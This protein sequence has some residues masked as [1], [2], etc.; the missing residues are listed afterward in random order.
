MSIFGL[1]RATFLAAALI[2]AGCDTS[3][4]SSTSGSGGIGGG[5]G[6]GGS[7]SSGRLV[8]CAAMSTDIISAPAHHTGD[9]N[10]LN[11][12]A[13]SNR[14]ARA[15]QSGAWSDAA[16]WGG[17]IPTSGA[18]V[19]PAGIGVILDT[20]L[21]QNL[22]SVRVDG[23]L[24]FARASN[25]RLRTDLLYVAPGGELWI[26]SPA[27]PI[28][29]NVTAEVIFPAT[30]KINAST[31]PRLLGKGLVSA[32]KATIA[33]ALKTSKV[34]TANAPLAGATTLS[35]A[36]APTGWNVGD[37]LVLTGTHLTRFRGVNGVNR[38]ENPEDEELTITAINGAS[39]TVSP[40]LR[41][42]H[43]TPR[44]SF[45]PYLVNFTRNVRLATENGSGKGPSE[46]GHSMFM[47]PQTIV[48]GAMFDEM[49][50]TDKSVRAFDATS[51][52]SITPDTNVKGRYPIHLHKAGFSSSAAPVLRNIA[53]WRSPGW[54]AAQHSTRAFFL[55]NA[56]YD[57]FG[58]GFV[59]ESGDERGAWVG[60]IAIK[61]EGVAELVK[62]G[63][64]VIAF[65]L[66][67]T[68]DGYWL[69]GRLLRLHRNVAAGMGAGMGFVYMHRG[70]DIAD[71][72]PITGDEVLRP[73]S[74]RFV[75]QSIDKPVIQQ[76]TQNE[77]F[78]SNIGFH[79]VKTGPKQPHDVRT[80]LDDFTAWEVKTG[81]EMT[82][83]SHYTVLNADICGTSAG[84]SAIG[85]DLGKNTYDLSV[86]NSRIENF[87]VGI[88]FAHVW[89]S[90][91]APAA[92]YVVAG[93]SL[94]NIR[95]AN[96]QNND[97]NDLILAST[98]ATKPAS[99]V[100][101]WGSSIP[102][103]NSA[104]G[105]RN[106][107]ITGTKTDTAGSVSYP[108]GNGDQDI[109]IPVITAALDANGYHTL[110]TGERI[111]TIPEFISDR[112]TGELQLQTFLI[113]I[114]PAFDVSS[115]RNNGALN[116]AGAAPNA[117][118]DTAIAQRNSITTINVL[119]N[120]SSPAGGLRIIGMTAPRNGYTEINSNGRI[121][122]SPYPGAPAS[123]AFS[124]W[125]MAADGKAAKADVSVTIQ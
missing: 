104:N 62:D 71:P 26:G 121:A 74:M 40:A 91:F 89:T 59:A 93:N 3:G 28:S 122:Y 123:D 115:Y 109:D 72:E 53:V 33:G 55:D 60:N 110:N 73:A 88:N 58:S 106:F 2:L 22:T 48:Q 79:V 16:T 10:A 36:S 67:R 78:A 116:P 12:I 87:D 8:T 41:F 92:F 56:V 42:N 43:D 69:Q 51:V 99:V 32:S 29:A 21:S 30:G 49:G 37:R 9:I 65:D 34:K 19:I 119:A 50:R 44:A 25:T 97:A 94:Q 86:A 77:V 120:D 76:F 63:A 52:A 66:G 95:V 100:F 46:R 7:G 81:I 14:G 102:F 85:I 17:S 11:S 45:Q 5:S 68:G 38:A 4:G 18:V 27:N 108:V 23:C 107:P 24:E 64:S 112:I 101:N 31:D 111:I 113:E 124:Y 35:L 80:V 98:P 84:N 15:A 70:T 61:S 20:Q 96:Y 90:T 47:S 118:A 83:T 13:P 117:N 105:F 54:G 75:G 57:A 103:W 39:V 1:K 6:S 82:Y 114:D 125:V